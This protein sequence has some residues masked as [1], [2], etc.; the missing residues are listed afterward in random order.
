[1]TSTLSPEEQERI[2]AAARQHANQVHLTDPA[3][4]VGIEA[5]PS[6]EP[7]WDY[8][9]GQAGHCH[10]DIMVQCIPAG[11]QAASNKSVNFNKL[12]EVVQGAD[13]NPAVFLNRLT[14]ALIQYTCLDPAS[15]A[16]GTVLASY[17]ISQSA[18]DIQKKFKKVEEGPQT[19]IQDLVK[20]AFK[21][22][23]SREEAAEAQRQAR[24]KQKVQLQTQALVAALRPAGS[25]SSQK[26]GTT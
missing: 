24:L 9:V 10:C 20:L 16:G 7:D 25:R 18:P 2:L 17:F 13:E 23:N 11:M 5:V 22:Y 6:A 3:M 14:E 26:R 4:P 12:K 21:V 8:Q 1:M 15:P 19:P